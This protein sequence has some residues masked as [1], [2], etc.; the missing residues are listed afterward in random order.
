[1]RKSLRTVNSMNPAMLYQVLKERIVTFEYMPG[2]TISETYLAEEYAISRTPVRTTLQRMELEYLVKVVP[3]KGTYI[4]YLNYN[5]IT[6][7]LYI[8]NHVER[9]AA[10]ELMAMSDGAVWSSLQA[11]LERCDIGTSE[12]VCLRSE[13]EFHRILHSATGNPAI[14]ANMEM[15]EDRCARYNTLKR[16]DMAQYKCEFLKLHRQMLNVLR[17]GDAGTVDQLL[18]QYYFGGME[19][20]RQDLGDDWSLYFADTP[21]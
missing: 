9:A 1:M 15:L 20:L 18:Y 11:V 21:T 7:I 19:H 2:S 14:W 17:Q 16:R 4:T 10:R 3:Q 12:A 5:Y 8:R 6:S 13:T